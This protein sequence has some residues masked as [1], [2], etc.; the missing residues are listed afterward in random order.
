MLAAM[1]VSWE[2]AQGC[3]RISFGP[4]I[5]EEQAL[6]LAD[7]CAANYTALRGLG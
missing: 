1:G 4:D 5:T 2:D 6:R 7:L 3:V